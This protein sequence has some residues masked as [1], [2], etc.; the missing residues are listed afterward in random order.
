MT[1]L[2]LNTPDMQLQGVET[3]DLAI[4]EDEVYHVLAITGCAAIVI[5]ICDLQLIRR[6]VVHLDKVLNILKIRQ[7]FKKYIQ[8]DQIWC[9]R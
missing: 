9:A 8:A 7:Q 5:C 4:K 6:H 2:K 1:T 3:S